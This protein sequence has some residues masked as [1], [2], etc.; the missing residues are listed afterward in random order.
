MHSFPSPDGTFSRHGRVAGL[1]PAI[2]LIN[3]DAR[4]DRLVHMRSEL[5]RAEAPFERVSAVNGG[6]LGEEEVQSWAFPLPAFRRLS[7]AEVGC[8]LSHRECWR[9]IVES[10]RDA[11]VVL[12]DDVVFSTVA[13]AFLKSLDW[14]PA[15]ADVVRLEAWESHS[16]VDTEPVAEFGGRKVHR[17]RS[18]QYGTAAYVIT[19][20]GAGKALR[21]SERFG[22]PADDF[23]FNPDLP[24]ARNFVTYQVVPGVCVQDA[25]LNRENTTLGSDIR[26]APKPD[27]PK[28]LRL[29]W[30]ETKRA[31]KKG[32]RPVK[33]YLGNLIGRRRW[34]LIEFQ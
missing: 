9:T 10:G 22:C 19:A 26:M 14:V 13:P 17:L 27:R 30:R 28:G 21:L 23:L 4:Q 20:K 7:A 32:F 18:V 5:K 11:G 25:R 33:M 3:L 2:L 15:D 29:V 16:V 1:A 31:L 24:F 6:L 12:E 34:M 8:F